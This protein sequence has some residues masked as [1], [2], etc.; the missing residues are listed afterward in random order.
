MA[1]Q[2]NEKFK[3][4]YEGPNEDVKYPLQV[5]YCGECGL[6][7][8]Y[9]ENGPEEDYEKCKKWLQD[10]VPDE[11]E[12]LTV[13]DANDGE[14]KEEGEKKKRQTRGGRGVAKSSKKKQA[15]PQKIT[16][17]RASR[18]KKKFVTVIRGL[19]SHDIDLRDAS[20]LFGQK[21][22]CGSSIPPAGDDEIVIQGNVKD[23]LI[24]LITEKWPK[25]DYDMI[26]DL[27]DKAR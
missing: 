25:I 7:V 11:F 1:T 22:S 21:F 19:G 4:S 6:P 14:E 12:R 24:A 15:A 23:D 8:E 16:V 17:F 13:T 3:L 18:G 20:K 5:L 2:G 9:C 27:G 10:N 26:N